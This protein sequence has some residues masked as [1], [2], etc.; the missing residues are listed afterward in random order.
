VTQIDRILETSE[1]RE[2]RALLSAA[3]ED[4][5]PEGSLRRVARGLGVAAV[6]ATWSAAAS[7]A[8]SGAAA[9]GASVAAPSI[10]VTPLGIGKWLAIGALAGTAA[11]GAGVA[12]DR[13]VLAPSLPAAPLA[14]VT[15]GAPPVVT[16]PPRQ[17]EPTLRP[18]AS[19]PEQPTAPNR[20]AAPVPE[21]SPPPTDSR[22]LAAEVQRIDQARRAL[23]GGDAPRALGELAA[24]QRER[25]LGVLDREATLLAIRAHQ[26]LGDRDRARDLARRFLAAHPNDAHAPR[27]RALLKER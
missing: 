8:V 7:G 27:L 16:N 24:Y 25:E 26:A 12:L 17:H 1:N 19:A 10:A 2:L 11:S 23:E 13:F 21:T 20:A 14:P 5:P 18:A 9:S 15:V 6:G 3:L 4:A 22:A